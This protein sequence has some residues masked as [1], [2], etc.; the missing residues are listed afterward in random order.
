MMRMQAASS[1]LRRFENEGDAFLKS[2]VTTD[3]MWV[4]HFI[5]ESQQSSREWRHTGSPRLKKARRTRSAGKVMATFFWDWQGVIHVDFLTE[6]KTVSVA[7]YSQLLATEIKK[8]I[9]FKRKRGEKW[10]AFLQDNARPHTAKTTM[11]T[12]VKL[13]WDLLPHLPYSPD[14]VP[15]DFYLFGRLK[16][17]LE[18]MRFADND[19][20]STLFGSGY[21]ANRKTFMKKALGCFQ[22]VGKNV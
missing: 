12:I 19:A 9:R 7:Y 20:S 16:S 15:S 10:V 17:D 5:P 21:A 6:A 14:L 8:K 13:K 22:N 11:E 1:L 18:G 3:E 2:I 4:H